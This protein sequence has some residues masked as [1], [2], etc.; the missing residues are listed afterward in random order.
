MSNSGRLIMPKRELE[1]HTWYWWSGL[2]YVDWRLATL[3][4]CGEG[5]EVHGR[6]RLPPTH[7]RWLVT[8]GRGVPMQFRSAQG[9]LVHPR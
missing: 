4:K 7:A 1:P 5:G 3:H 9:A 6:L 8:D 2:D